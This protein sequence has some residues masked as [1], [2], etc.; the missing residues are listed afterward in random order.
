MEKATYRTGYLRRKI[1]NIERQVKIQRG[2]KASEQSSRPPISQK[3]RKTFGD[4]PKKESVY[5]Q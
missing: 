5:G 2:G 1:R 3:K 4:L